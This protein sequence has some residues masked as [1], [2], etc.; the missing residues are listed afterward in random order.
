MNDSHVK[1]REMQVMV[2]QSRVGEM[3]VTG[4]PIKM[5]DYPVQYVKGSPDLGE[6]N[7]EVFGGLG[8]TPEQLAQFRADGVIG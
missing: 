2:P 4:N 6:D 5:S 3:Q 1:A 7:D 8:F